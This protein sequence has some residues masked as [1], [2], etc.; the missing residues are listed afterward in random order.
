MTRN[1]VRRLHQHK[2]RLLPGFTA[3]YNIDQLL[4]YE[5]F[6]YVNDAIGREKE[7]KGWRKE[8][9]IALIRQF[10]PGF[11]DLTRLVLGPE[12]QEFGAKIPR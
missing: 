12:S 2:H 7:I 5:S 3:R 4:Y 9:K 8:K 10:N 1:L 6:R 11:E